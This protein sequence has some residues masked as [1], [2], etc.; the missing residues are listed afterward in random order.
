MSNP[1][2]RP[3]KWGEPTSLTTVRLPDSIKDRLIRAAA[4]RGPG[5]SRTDLLVEALDKY[6]PK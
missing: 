1:A 6:L 5:T 4:R 3:P 2:H